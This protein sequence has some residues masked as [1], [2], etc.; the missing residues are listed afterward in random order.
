[1]NSQTFNSSAIN[2]SSLS[3]SQLSTDPNNSSVHF[4]GEINRPNT[5]ETFCNTPNPTEAQFDALEETDKLQSFRSY[6]KVILCLFHIFKRVEKLKNTKIF[7]KLKSNYV[8]TI[9][10]LFFNN[11]QKLSLHLSH[12]NEILSFRRKFPKK[13]I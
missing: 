9:C 13:I 8:S 5:V 10:I 3:W 11:N 12:Q 4:V 1:M 2:N 6:L 7:F